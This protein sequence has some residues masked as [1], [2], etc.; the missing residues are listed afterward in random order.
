M[1]RADFVSFASKVVLISPNLLTAQEDQLGA[2]GLVANIIVLWNTWY[3]QEALDA[4]RCS[5]H[6]VR[7]EDV[8]RLAPLRFQH[9]NIHGRYH[10]TLPEAVAQGRRRP[11]RRPSSSPEERF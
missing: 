4:L 10:F 2:L 11:L 6:E 7:P 1:F 8:E 9:I 3:M 5:G